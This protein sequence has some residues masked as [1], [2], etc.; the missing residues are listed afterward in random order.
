MPS[1]LSYPGVYVEEI[2]SGVR[3][4]TAVPTSTTAFIGSATK[5]PTNEAV[6][7][8]SFGDYDRVFGGL[9]AK[10]AMSYAVRDFYMNGGTRAVIVRLSHPNYVDAAARTAGDAAAKQI[11]DAAATKTN[12]K[13]AKDA[14]N[15]ANNT[16]Q[17]ATTATPI[18]K[19]VAQAAF[20]TIN[21]LAGGATKAEVTA[22]A[23]AISTPTVRAIT[24]GPL[25]FEASSPG[26]WAANLR[27]TVERP[28]DSNGQPSSTAADAAK[29]LN[30]QASDIFTLTVTDEG[31]GGGSETF[32]TVT[33]RPSIRRIDKVL[34]NESQLLLWG[35]DSL[36]TTPLKL[37]DVIPD[38]TT[39]QKDYHPRKGDDVAEAQAALK[40]AKAANPDPTSYQVQQQAVDAAIVAAQA[41][42]NDGGFLD[43]DDFLPD[44][45]QTDKKGLY[46]LEQLFTRGGIFNLLCIP[47]YRVGQDIAVG[48]MAAAAAL[49]EQRR[50]MFIVDPPNNWKSVTAA[51]NN[52]GSNVE[53]LPRTKNAAVFFPNV[54]QPN[55]LHDDQVEDFPPCG[56]V[57]GIFA[58][59]DA[60]RGVWK[61]PAGLDASMVGVSE[62]NVPM[63]DEENGLLN[64]LG[65]NCLR[66]FPIFGRVVWGARTLRGADDYGDEYKYIA[67]RRAALF[68]EESL[69]RGLKWVVFE[70]NDEPLWAQIRLN[71][72]AFMHNLFRQGAFQGSSPRDA[73]FV[74][75]DSS[76]T[77][78]ND[79][80]LGIVNIAVGF[81]PLKPAE[82]VVIKLQQMA[83][84]I[85]T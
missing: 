50:A 21:Q 67:V 74:K 6:E 63:T 43:T 54:R 62:L 55:P 27:V 42:V 13:D 15:T 61:S 1:A 8:T 52:F 22:A 80:N 82:F 45:G 19:K 7:I 10:S 31:V 9:W 36:D 65:I 56:V 41:S 37:S 77:T 39:G 58:R 25:R 60:Q 16:I 83:G 78:Q 72:G 69:Y 2:P 24:I 14:A 32:S 68:I 85:D 51:V 18:A 11:A 57:T 34:Q 48:L 84:Q 33:L 26:S 71:V 5:G 44:Q 30:V 76:T 53:S 29:A 70:P 81:A 4:I 17:A 35:G 28:Y 75:C 20:V 64:P 66:T 49:C 3:T 47:P 40:R 38:P 73:Y 12:G 46:S 59:T 23:A 79:I